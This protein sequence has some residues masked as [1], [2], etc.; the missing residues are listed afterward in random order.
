MRWTTGSGRSGFVHPG[1]GGPLVRT[2]ASGEPRDRGTATVELAIAMVGIVLVM[3]A[4]LTVAG[5]GVARL[6]VEDAARAGT[7]EAIT[8]ASDAEIVAAATRAAR[9]GARVQIERQDG[10]VSV[11]VERP[12]VGRWGTWT[13]EGRRTGRIEPLVGG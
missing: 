1:R 10:W 13:V 9:D 8:G 7:R 6:D 4:V 5:V 2:S 3:T 12:V 11:R